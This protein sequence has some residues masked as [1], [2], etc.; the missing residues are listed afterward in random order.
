MADR[1]HSVRVTVELI[2]SRLFRLRYNQRESISET[3]EGIRRSGTET[4]DEIL[5][6]RPP[7]PLRGRVGQLQFHFPSK[8]PKLELTG[9]LNFV[10]AFGLYTISGTV[11]NTGTAEAR[12]V[13]V[14]VTI[15]PGAL[16][17]WTVTN[18][19]GRSGRSRSILRDG[20]FDP[21]QAIR[22]SINKDA[23]R[24]DFRI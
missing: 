5:V 13:K 7:D 18:P 21:D 6:G 23:T 15:Y 2:N 24:V 19:T 8:T 17:A 22:N 1:F 20:F 14:Y 11:K 10:G 3:A 4:N 12:T 9:K 16:T